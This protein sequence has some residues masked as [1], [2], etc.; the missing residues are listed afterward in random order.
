[1]FSKYVRFER[2]GIIVFR[3]GPHKRM[4]EWFP[5]DRIV[6]A[7]NVAFLGDKLKCYGESVSLGCIK[8][9]PEDSEIL[10]RMLGN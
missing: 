6:S 1:M 10:N 5:N 7:G 2:A 8:S 3:D 4:A 9:L